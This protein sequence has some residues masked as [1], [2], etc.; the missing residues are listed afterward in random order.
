MWKVDGDRAYPLR[1][2][3]TNLFPP[4]PP[5]LC[6]PP[7]LTP[8]RVPLSTCY[9][10]EDEDE[11]AEIP[12]I[13]HSP[14]FQ[15]PRNISHAAWSFPEPS[16]PPLVTFDMKPPPTPSSVA[17]ENLTNL[18]QDVLEVMN[19][20]MESR[21]EV[22]EEDSI[23]QEL[24]ELVVIMQEEAEM[25]VEVSD[26]VEEYCEEIESEAEIQ[27]MEE[28]CLELGIGSGNQPCKNGDAPRLGHEREDSGVGLD[29]EYEED[30]EFMDDKSLQEM[31]VPSSLVENANGLLYDWDWERTQSFSEEDRRSVQTPTVL[32]T[33]PRP[34]PKDAKV[35]KNSK[36]VKMKDPVS[37]AKQSTR[38]KG[39]EKK[40]P[41]PFRDSGLGLQI[42]SPRGSPMPRAPR[43]I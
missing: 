1:H 28:W 41:P 39:K 29:E 27:E 11:D 26:L 19:T 2:Q 8:D 22:E 21:A 42:P 13:Y 7:P 31:E 16:T 43:W 38:K 24:T 3:H 5:P 10:D 14:L 9:E 4:R 12:M 6:V 35:E 17:P 30:E 32:I 34:T 37:K 33:P 15:T 23:L 36:A 18:L 25:L 20:I 40:I